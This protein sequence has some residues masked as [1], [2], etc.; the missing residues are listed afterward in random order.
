MVNGMKLL[1][2]QELSTKTYSGGLKS[3]RISLK[4][5]RQFENQQNPQRCHVRLSH[6]FLSKHP[7]E[8]D[9]FYSEAKKNWTKDEIRFTSRPLG[10][11][12]LSGLISNVCST[13]GLSGRNKLNHFLKVTCATRLYQSNVDE[14]M[15]MERTGHRS[16]AGVRAYKRTCNVHP[17]FLTAIPFMTFFECV[18]QGDDNTCSQLCPE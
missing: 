11:N 9:R 4:H 12:Q 5:V 8:G 6:I 1:W 14:Q 10:K 7:T 13:V 17:Q 16:L 15:I 2:Y 3:Q 18:F